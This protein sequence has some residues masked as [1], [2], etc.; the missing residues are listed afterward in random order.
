MTVLSAAWLEDG[1]AQEVCEML[2]TGG[3]QAWFVGGCVRN[4]LLDAPVTDLD[5][6]TDAHPERVI[7]L[8]E[9]A[10]LKAVPTGI[11]HGTITV[12]HDD[13]PF[14]ITTFRRDVETDGRRAVVAF[15]ETIEEDAQR[16]D[17]TI[18]A[19]YADRHGALRDPVG[20][21]ADLPDRRF[22]F[23]GLAEDRIREDYLRILRFFRFFAWYGWELDAEGLAACAAHGD[24]LASLSAER[25][26]SEVLKLLSAEDPAPAVA[27]MEHAGIL[28]RTLPGASTKVLGPF[29]HFDP[30]SELDPMARLA[31][32]GGDVV[33]LRLSKAEARLHATYRSIMEGS[34]TP[35]ALG[36]HHGAPVAHRGLALRAAALETPLMDTDIA[37]ASRGAAAV[38]PV[39]AADLPVR[40]QG[41]EIGATLKALE[42]VWIA[43]DFS[44]SKEGLLARL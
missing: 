4:A 18:N 36:F 40:L 37:S 27:A 22:R 17:F 20:G 28:H 31:A 11:D 25:V 19:L 3:H 2:E 5:I 21:L 10:G 8:A 30:V 14:E 9:A 42:K 26:T 29:L 33:A 12:V 15:A 24:G 6:S 13:Q 16:R 34:D 41:P 32:L 39:R 38:F 44:L 7:A 1:A 43:S 35:G 23:I